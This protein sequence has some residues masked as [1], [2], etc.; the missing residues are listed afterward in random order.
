MTP[1]YPE[2]NRSKIVKTTVWTTRFRV[3]KGRENGIH[4]RIERLFRNL[5]STFPIHYMQSNRV[6]LD[7]VRVSLRL[8]ISP[9][10]TR[11]INIIII[12]DK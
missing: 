12:D 4:L 2:I 9:P 7:G 6:L 11:S 1:T 3:V 5:R 10:N 8:V